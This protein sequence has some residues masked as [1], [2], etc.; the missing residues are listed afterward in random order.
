[1]NQGLSMC[2]RSPPL[3]RRAVR[4]TETGCTIDVPSQPKVVMPGLVP[5]IH[6][7]PGHGWNRSW[8]VDGRIK[9]GHDGSRLYAHQSTT[10]SEPTRF[11]PDSPATK[12]GPLNK[13]RRYGSTRLHASD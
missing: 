8:H 12:G 7:C 5:G 2:Y 1:M 13:R 4:G 10:G 3:S 11:S 9:S 6:A